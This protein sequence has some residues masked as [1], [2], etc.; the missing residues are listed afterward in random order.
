MTPT[1]GGNLVIGTVGYSTGSRKNGYTPSTPL[2]QNAYKVR[3]ARV[4]VERA[5]REALA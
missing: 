2:G 3:L 5:L 1:K 4:M